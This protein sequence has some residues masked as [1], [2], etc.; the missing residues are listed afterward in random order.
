[1]FVYELLQEELNETCENVHTSRLKAV[2]DV[3]AGLQRSQSLV[4]AEMGRK[5]SGSIDIKHK[6]KKVDRL[7]G[8]KKLHGELEE[9]YSGLSSYIFKYLTFEMHAPIIVDLCYIQ[10][11]QDIQM[12]SAEI[13]LKGRTLPIYREVFAKTG[14]KN[15][16][17]KFLEALQECLPTGHDIVIIMDAG[18]GEEWIQAIES[19]HWNWILRI[20]TG[21]FI[22]L[23]DE[24]EWLGANELMPLIE[25]K[26]KSYDKAYITKQQPHSCR[27]VTKEAPKVLKRKK[28]KELPRN[29]NAANGGYRK[30]GKEP[31]ILASN[32]P[33]TYKTTQII[34]Y[35]KKRMQIEESF[36]DMKNTR[37]GLCAR[38][39]NT[40]CVH[41]WGVKMLLAAIVQIVCW[42]IGIIGH[43]LNYQRKFQAN[44]VKDRK[45]FSYFYLGKLIIEHDMISTIP[46]DPEKLPDIIS[47]ELAR[48]W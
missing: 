27:I 45:V 14:L 40:K 12:L 33:K 37:Y 46:I 16:A 42:I 43:S 28:P 20:R 4:Q 47:Q 44:T 25:G 21:K 18:F 41:R 3:A 13:A 29:Y 6:I 38:Q 23:T 1:M 24:A 7:E 22:K 34:N 8:N 30:A 36:R 26:A 5:L 11:D 48:E 31:L 10:D 39:A 17:E 32:L 9:I 2:L 19:Y 35:Y 15:R